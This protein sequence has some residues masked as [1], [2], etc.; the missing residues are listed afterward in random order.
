MSNRWRVSRKEA[1]T[2]L[3]QFLRDKCPEAPSVKA[4]KRA[5]D[6][7]LCTVNGRIETFS[8]YTLEENDLVNLSDIPVE[9]KEMRVSILYEDDEILVANKPAGMLTDLRALQKALNQP[10]ILVHRLDKETSGALILAKTPKAKDKM[11][12]L[13]KVH[14]VRK[15]YLAIVDKPLEKAEGKIENFLGKKHS[16]QGQTIYGA[17]DEKKGQRAITYWKRLAQCK[18]ASVVLCEPY[19]GRTH[20]LRVHLSGMGH[21]ILGDVQYGKKFMSGYKPRRNLLHAY[22]IAFPFNGKDLK[23]VAPI[24]SDFREA[25]AALGMSL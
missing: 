18:S 23:I 21:P 15:H 17:V 25:L 20:Q 12:D 14:K 4:L 9:K 24:P 10:L 19:T 2:R 7:K 5:L 22:S 6:G 1:G 8:S 16:Y 3:L 11:V 13:F